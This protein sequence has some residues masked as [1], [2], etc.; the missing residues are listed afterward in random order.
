MP[1]FGLIT[2]DL[3]DVI[4]C[5]AMDF[6]SM[7]DATFLIPHKSAFKLDAEGVNR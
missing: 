1:G 6:N 4:N 2:L 7:T 3:L 5:S